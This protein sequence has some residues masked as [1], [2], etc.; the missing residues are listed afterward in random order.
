MHKY[1]RME[2]MVRIDVRP[3]TSTILQDADKKRLQHE[4]TAEKVALDVTAPLSSPHAGDFGVELPDWGTSKALLV[5]QLEKGFV[6]SGIAYK[7]LNLW[8]GRNLMKT[9]GAW[10][11]LPKVRR[12]DLSTMLSRHRARYWGVKNIYRLQGCDENTPM[13]DLAE[14]AAP[15]W[16][17][18]YCS[19]IT[20]C[21]AMV[22]GL[23]PGSP[24]E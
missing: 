3:L 20:A 2:R 24:I 10:S 8:I 9:G 15:L 19:L 21:D 5:E 1:A 12:A 6:L 7:P 4:V 22:K 23:V 14:L 18:H 13:A 17:G 16:R 11:H